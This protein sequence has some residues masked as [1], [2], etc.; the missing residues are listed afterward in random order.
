MI[1]FARALSFSVGFLSLSQEI[2]WVRLIS[3]ATGSL[4]Q[5]FGFVLGSF[6]VGIAFGAVAGKRI[7][8][9]FGDLA[10]VGGMVLVAAGLVDLALPWLAANALSL[11]APSHLPAL[12]VLI[13]S[14][15]FLKSVLFPIAHHLGTVAVGDKVGVSVSRVYFANILGSTMGPLVTGLILLDAFSLDA[16]FVIVGV[17]TAVIGVVC[18]ARRYRGLRLVL[19]LAPVAVAAVLAMQYPLVKTLILRDAPDK[20]PIKFVIQNRHG[21]VHARADDHGGDWIYGGNAYDGRVNTDLLVDSNGIRRVYLLAALH[22]SAKRILLIGLGSGSWM[23]VLAGFPS[24]TSVDVVEIN[25]GYADVIAH[26]PDTLATSKVPGVHL[27]WADGRNWLNQQGDRKFDLIV[28][29]TTFHWRAYT[30]MLLSHEF[31]QLVHNHLADGGVY[32]FNSTGSPD[33]HATASA[34]FPNIYSFE[35]FVVASDRQLAMDFD[36]AAH[37]LARVSLPRGRHLNTGDPRV[38]AK[39]TTMVAE[40]HPYVPIPGAQVITDGNMLTEYRHGTR[41]RWWH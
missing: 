7:C 14:S 24:M 15:A 29:N 1:W 5:S 28:V 32:A 36:V 34:V 41:L 27:I 3:F 9:R 38:A 40:F 10:T 21:I 11:P 16:S 12:A 23:D 33:A 22:P 18:L 35:T 26:Y 19:P 17:L 2:L 37:R 13:A 30:T 25:P 4:P 31:M 8:E 39:I 20:R 6:L